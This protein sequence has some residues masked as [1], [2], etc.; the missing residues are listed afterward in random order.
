MKKRKE[1]TITRFFV[2]NTNHRHQQVYESRTEEQNNINNIVSPKQ[3]IMRKKITDTVNKQIKLISSPT[4]LTTQKNNL[5]YS[6]INAANNKYCAPINTNHLHSI[7]HQ[8]RQLIYFFSCGHKKIITSNNIS[9]H[10]KNIRS[11]SSH[12]QRHTTTYFHC[13]NFH[14]TKSQQDVVKVNI[15]QK[16]LTTRDKTNQDIIPFTPDPSTNEMTQ[17]HHLPPTPRLPKHKIVLPCLDRISYSSQI[18]VTNV[19]L[20]EITPQGRTRLTAPPPHSTIL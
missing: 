19:H 9:S 4:T 12:G 6:D 3:G 16:I 13:K 5:Q 8:T 17:Q 18:V 1:T 7:I 20:E 2:Q 14:Q 11:Q 15:K 10:S